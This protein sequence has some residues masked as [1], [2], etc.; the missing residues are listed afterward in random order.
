MELKSTSRATGEKETRRDKTIYSQGQKEILKAWFQHDPY[1]DKATKELLARAIGVPESKIRSWFKQHRARQ[2]QL[3]SGYCL[4][5]DQS[6]K[7]SHPQRC[8][9]DQTFIMRT[10]RNKLVEAFER[11]PFPDIDSREKLAIQTGIQGS[12]IEVWFQNQRSLYPEQSPWEPLDLSIIGPNWRPDLTLQQQQIDMSSLSDRS[13]HFPSTNAFSGNETFMP[14]HLPFCEYSVPQDPFRVCL[15]QGP[16][17]RITQPTQAVQEGEDSD[18]SLTPRSHL[19]TL[20]TQGEDFSDTQT[21]FP[22]PFQ[23]EYPNHEEHSGTSVQLEGYRQ[24][25]PKHKEKQCWYLGPENDIPYIV[26]WWDEIC[27]AL[28]AEWDPLKGTH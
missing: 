15:S 7:H 8:C 10:Q 19:P 11:N 14:V 28:I 24:P 20:S 23:E 16:D 22:S 5:H 27:Q 6:Q 17:V 13:P 25:Q 3:K 1:P 21:P 26:Q 2:R 9:Q 12:E 4:G 18:Q